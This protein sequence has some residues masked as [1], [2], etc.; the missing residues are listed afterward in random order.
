MEPLEIRVGHGIDV[1][2]LEAG[3]KLFLGGVEIPHDKGLS[4]HSDADVLLHA[5]IDALQGATGG[6]DIGAVFPNTDE[7]WRGADSSNLLQM[8][9]Q[10]LSERGWQVINVDCVLLAEQPKLQPHINAIKGRVAELLQI[11]P[12][13]CGIKA[14]T[15]E[16]LG[17][18]GRSEGIVAS[19]TVLLQ[20]PGE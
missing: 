19:V 11:T 12:S 10:P 14:T 2:P 6:Q 16:G 5:V 20:G 1:H 15:S 3:R 9:W 18:V 17:F 8:V 13:R 7:R 4:G